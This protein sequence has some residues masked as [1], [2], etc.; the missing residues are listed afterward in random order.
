MPQNPDV[1]TITEVGNIQLVNLPDYFYARYTIKNGGRTPS[2]I[3][4]KQFFSIFADALPSEVHYKEPIE[5][6][7]R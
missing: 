3:Y 1:H 4:E 6:G 5:R 7:E 2:I